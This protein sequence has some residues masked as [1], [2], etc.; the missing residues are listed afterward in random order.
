LHEGEVNFA[1]S[2]FDDATRLHDQIKLRGLLFWQVSDD[3]PCV[4]LDETLRH[5]RLCIPRAF[6]ELK[7]GWCQAANKEH[8][9]KDAPPNRQWLGVFFDEHDLDHACD[10][11][12]HPTSGLWSE[13]AFWTLLFR[14]SSKGY[15][16]QDYLLANSTLLSKARQ[17][18]VYRKVK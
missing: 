12:H 14:A 2:T 11:Y 13:N 16:G 10:V 1:A 5:F 4:S 7:D 6:Q 17:M 8:L 15:M 18:V 9:F 3:K